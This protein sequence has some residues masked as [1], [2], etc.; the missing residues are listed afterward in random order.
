MLPAES[1]GRIKGI[2]LVG[3]SM[4][5]V[6]VTSLALERP[7][8]IYPSTEDG[9]TAAL[10]GLAYRGLKAGTTII[11]ATKVGTNLFIKLYLSGESRLERAWTG[12][13][14]GSSQTFMAGTSAGE[15][16]N[17]SPVR[18][19]LNHL[20]ARSGQVHLEPCF[21]IPNQLLS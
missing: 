15:S 18:N 2:P 10:T 6:G 11:S 9:F 3:A 8:S 20:S 13:V 7:I 5:I 17:P 19:S 4:C 21:P 16:S 12:C 14:P 1:R